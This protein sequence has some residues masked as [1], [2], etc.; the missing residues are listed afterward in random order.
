MRKTS[1]RN[2]TVH[3]K[4]FQKQNK[5]PDAL[6]PYS[7]KTSRRNGEKIPEGKRN[8]QWH[9]NLTVKKTSRRNGA[10]QRKKLSEKQKLLFTSVQQILYFR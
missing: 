6:A 9:W 8:F 7:G 4:N 10:L 3:R 2:G 1:K 5:L